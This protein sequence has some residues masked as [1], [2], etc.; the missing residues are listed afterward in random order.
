MDVKK[1]SLRKEIK[2]LVKC[3]QRNKQTIMEGMAN[4]TSDAIYFSNYCQ[5]NTIQSLIVSL[6]LILHET[7]PK[8]KELTPVTD[9]EWDV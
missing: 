9:P 3:L 1:P 7:K 5:V 8:R 6:E 2:Y 4:Y